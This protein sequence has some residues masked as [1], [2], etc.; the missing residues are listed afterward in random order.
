MV[1]L[2]PHLPQLSLLYLHVV[3]VKEEEGG[4]EGGRGSHEESQL[5]MHVYL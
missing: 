5:W 2:I 4:G 3:L 1:L